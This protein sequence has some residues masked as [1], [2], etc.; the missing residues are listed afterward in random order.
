MA[1]KFTRAGRP[2]VRKYT[3]RIFESKDGTV[4]MKYLKKKNIERHNFWL[5]YL[6]V[7][8]NQACK[9]EERTFGTPCSVASALLSSLTLCS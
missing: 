1:R 8:S 2:F 4:T 3:N 9:V 5:N 7:K 6:P